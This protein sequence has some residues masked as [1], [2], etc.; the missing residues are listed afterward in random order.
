MGWV[1]LTD[2]SFL[3]VV[4]AMFAAAAGLG[5]AAAAIA[6]IKRAQDSDYDFAAGYN[7]LAPMLD[8]ASN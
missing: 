8:Q 3:G 7:A 2:A 4:W 5:L 1:V 6:F